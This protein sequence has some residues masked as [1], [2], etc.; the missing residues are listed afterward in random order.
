[1]PDAMPVR[2]KVYII[3]PRKGLNNSN[4]GNVETAKERLSFAGYEPI[5]DGLEEIDIVD[6][7][8]LDIW[9]REMRKRLVALCGADG[10]CLMPGWTGDTG[11]ALEYHVAR[12]LK[13]K[14]TAID[15][16]TVEPLTWEMVQPE[17][18]AELPTDRYA[19]PR[20]W[21][22][23]FVRLSLGQQIATAESV[24]FLQRY[25]TNLQRSTV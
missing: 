8:S 24:I 3:S 22:D 11:S 14:V 10:A 6:E 4:R 21:R 19:S 5:W 13:M 1:M 9:V 12:N 15:N 25:F 18:P 7:P 23:W 17:R 2:L 20:E 16:W